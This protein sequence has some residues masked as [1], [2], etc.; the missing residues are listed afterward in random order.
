MFQP[1][2][3]AHPPF[4]LYAGHAEL[5]ERVQSYYR[6]E[7]TDEDLFADLLS[8]IDRVEQDRIENL[9]SERDPD[10]VEVMPA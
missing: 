10:R 4:D 8:K 9:D 6:P 5:R 2:N 7:T 1:Y 3:N